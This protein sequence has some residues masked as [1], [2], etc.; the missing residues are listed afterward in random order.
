MVIDVV[1]DI[2][3][4]TSIGQSELYRR[5]SRLRI[6]TAMLD[7]EAQG[8]REEVK[9]IISARRHRPFSCYAGAPAVCRAA[10]QGG[11]VG[12]RYPSLNERRNKIF[13]GE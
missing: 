5:L 12:E 13:Y 10:W 1:R 2:A 8:L 3:F 11:G 4:M 9:K 7:P 6:R